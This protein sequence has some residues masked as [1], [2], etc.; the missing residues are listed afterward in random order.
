VDRSFLLVWYRRCRLV[1]LGP[2]LLR[3]EAFSLLHRDTLEKGPQLVA[4][5]PSLRS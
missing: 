4:G 5:L 1:E 3:H 2:T